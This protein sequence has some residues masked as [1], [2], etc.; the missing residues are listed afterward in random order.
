MNPFALDN[1]KPALKDR[2]ILLGISGSIAAFKA[3]DIV[4]HL[5][6]AGAEVRVVLTDSATRFVTPTTLENLSG[7]PV[8]TSLWTDGDAGAHGTHHIEAARWA[9][10]ALVAPA[11]ANT[12]AKL[13]LGLADDLLCTELL[14]FRGPLVVA[15]A[16]NPAMFEHPAVQAN[17]ELLRSRDVVVAGPVRGVT[18]CGEEGSGRML[19]PEDIL[20]VVARALAG[21]YGRAGKP[22]GK[23]LLITLGPTRSALDPVRY[24]TNRSSG[25]MGASIAWAAWRE[26]YQV[27]AVCGP[28]PA[29]VPLP[30]GIA[31]H[32]V[33]TAREMLEIAR[34]EFEACDVFVASAAVLDW[35]VSTP[36]SEKLKKEDGAPSLA[37]ERNPDILA[38]LAAGKRPGQFV[39]GFAAETRNVVEA[40]VRKRLLKNCDAL[41]A[42][43]VSSSA[44]G[45]ESAQNGGFW[46]ARDSLFEIGVRDKPELATLLLHL[47]EGRRSPETGQLRNLQPPLTKEPAGVPEPHPFTRPDDA[48][49]S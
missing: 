7:Q 46:I 16:M 42:N 41:F 39:L 44:H 49:I 33:Q 31:V 4:R 14:A 6:A 47:L 24:L 45:L 1:L 29:D 18:A 21:N 2:R 32:R 35:D 10:L 25:R 38:T 20:P 36:S 27:T 34:A 15:P 17:L 12:I 13:A 37:L 30:P 19:E 28:L 23:R 11:T 8:H 40:G 9:D 43:D 22:P 5:R 48:R 3:C 26:G